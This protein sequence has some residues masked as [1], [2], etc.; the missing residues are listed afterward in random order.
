MTD[1]FSLARPVLHALPPEA[2]HHAAL[3]ALC[4]GL[5]PGSAGVA[6]PALVQTLFGLAFKNPVG[7][8]AGFDKNAVAIDALLKQ[9]F[10]FVEA[11]TVTP[12]PQPGNPKPRLFRLSEDRAVINRLGFNNQGL[13]RFTENF[14]RRHPALGIAGANIGKNKDATDAV[15]D[16]VTG[17]QAV[18]AHA[19]YVTINISS[20]NTKGLRDLQSREALT[21]LLAALLHTRNE[22][23]AAHKKRIPLLLKIAPDLDAGQCE[24]IA[25]A[26]SE[27]AID[28]LIVSNTTI[29]RPESLASPHRAE[30]G[31]LSGVP[32]FD[33]STKTLAIMHKLTGGTLPLIGVGGIA[34][35]Q[36]AY[37]KIRAGASLVQLY[38]ALVY[39]GFGLVQRINAELP[40]LLARDGFSC[41]S[42][43]VGVGLK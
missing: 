38:S 9:G 3:R 1:L 22:L 10:G 25:Q 18:Y 5:L 33:L 42:E 41:V 17:L 19:D 32:L 29:S 16:Y 28:G 30:A 21:Q 4:S 35:P 11:G 43:A 2:A 23:Q 7:L 13:A 26:I 20:P 39:Q 15:A 34:S 14:S 27:H 8:A 31:G 24:D 40:G 37:A 6:H 12:L 36:D